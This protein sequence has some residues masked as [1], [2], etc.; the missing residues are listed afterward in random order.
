MWID[1]VA[2]DD[3]T[4]ALAAIYRDRTRDGGP[5]DNIIRAHSLNPNALRALMSFY[6]G[7]MH[8]DCAISLRRREMI[9]VTVSALN[10][11]FY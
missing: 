11:C 10:D 6:N 4:G 3:A 9:A 8:G 2:Q 7:V 1:H 5:L